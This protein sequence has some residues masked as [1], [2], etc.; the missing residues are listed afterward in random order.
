[1]KKGRLIPLLAGVSLCLLSPGS[2][3]RARHRTADIDRWRPVLHF[4]E[5]RRGAPGRS[6]EASTRAR[7]GRSD[8]PSKVCAD[9][10]VR[11]ARRV[12]PAPPVPRGQAALRVQRAL[13]LRP[14]PSRAS[15]A[16]R[17]SRAAG[18][19]GT[20]AQGAQGAG[21]QGLQGRKVTRA[22]KASP[23]SPAFPR[24]PCRLRCHL[25]FWRLVDR[26]LARQPVRDLQ[27]HGRR[28]RP[29]GGAGAKG[30]TGRRTP[31]DADLRG[32][33]VIRVPLVVR[34]PG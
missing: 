19:A 26:G 12:R 7:S 14:P 29:D 8:S 10:P 33:K 22:R 21:A 24:S 9:P 32:R 5:D 27:R 6:E 1:M 30:D 2:H 23:A 31:G 17:E 34:S 25:Y 3:P 15:P 11:R 18:A 20:Q 4:E 28:R 13:R 16:R